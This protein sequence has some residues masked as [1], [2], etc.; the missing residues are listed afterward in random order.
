MYKCKYTVRAGKQST[1]VK[2]PVI[3]RIGIKISSVVSS[4]LE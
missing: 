2:G 3:W 4:D 1:K